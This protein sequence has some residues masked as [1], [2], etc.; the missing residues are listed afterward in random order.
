[1]EESIPFGNFLDNNQ[2]LEEIYGTFQR[3]SLLRQIAAFH[4]DWRLTQEK[5]A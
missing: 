3:N 5:C 4:S 2:S 1:M